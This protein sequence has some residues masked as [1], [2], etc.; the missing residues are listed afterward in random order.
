MRSIAVIRTLSAIDLH[1]ELRSAAE[2]IDDIGSKRML[3]A[4]QNSP[5]CLRRSRDHNLISASVGVRRNLRASGEA[6]RRW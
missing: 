1:D 2:A 6:M 5:S 4:K 3:A